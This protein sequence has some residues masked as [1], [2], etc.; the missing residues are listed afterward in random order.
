MI[1]F[2]DKK[3]NLLLKEIND[4]KA[5]VQAI[6]LQTQQSQPMKPIER[7]GRVIRKTDE[8]LWRIEKLENDKKPS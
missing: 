7:L 2:T 3:F 4:L 1:I 5:T 6:Y 8:Q